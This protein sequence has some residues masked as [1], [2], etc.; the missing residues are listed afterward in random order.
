MTTEI[1]MPDTLRGIYA[2][3]REI[4]PVPDPSG[5]DVTWQL[6]RYL[7]VAALKANAR[8]EA[9]V[10][11]A[12]SLSMETLAAVHAGIA[13]VH[14]NEAGRLG[15]PSPADGGFAAEVAAAIL[16]G[17]G[18]GEWLWIHS[19]ALGIDANEVVRLAEA[20]ARLKAAGVKQ[21]VHVKHGPG[22][23]CTPCKAEPSY[24]AR[25]G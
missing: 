6:S 12:R 20:E 21:E 7:L 1:T 13:A 9:E 24:E 16:D 14:L 25:R 3:L 4:A 17:D 10:L 5:T 15:H 19:R 2:R 18:I 23:G 11:S 8:A 22:C